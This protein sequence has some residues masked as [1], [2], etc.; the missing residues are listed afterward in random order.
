MNFDREETSPESAAIDPQHR[1]CL[2]IG[3]DSGHYKA[4]HRLNDRAV[5]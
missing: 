5:A 3:A 2:Y 4:W 1:R